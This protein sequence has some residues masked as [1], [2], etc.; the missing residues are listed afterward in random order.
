MST[1]KWGETPESAFFIEVSG[2]IYGIS[3]LA[4]TKGGCYDLGTKR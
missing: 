3:R 4:K 1:G 2:W